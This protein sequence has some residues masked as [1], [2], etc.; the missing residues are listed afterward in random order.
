MHLK[1]CD[2]LETHGPSFE[3]LSGKQKILG[4]TCSGKIV[5]IG[6]NISGFSVGDKVVAQG[7]G[8]WAQ[9]CAADYRRV[10]PIP[11]PEM[12]LLQAGT[13]RHGWPS[14]SGET[15]IALSCARVYNVTC[16]SVRMIPH[17]V[18]HGHLCCPNCFVLA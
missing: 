5:E 9:F 13:K 18:G 2:L 4:A 17:S 12:S 14:S 15:T 6:S 3:H 11:S 16:N 1:G 10:L 7:S 8:G